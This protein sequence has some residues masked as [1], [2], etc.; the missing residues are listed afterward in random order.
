MSRAPKSVARD[1]AREIWNERIKNCQIPSNVAVIKALAERGH[2]CTKRTLMRWRAAPDSG[3]LEALTDDEKA[4]RRAKK[5]VGDALHI[6]ADTTPE[7][8]EEAAKNPEQA[9]AGDRD[10]GKRFKALMEMSLPDLVRLQT[11]T[12]A[13]MATIANECMIYRASVLVNVPKDLGAFVQ[14]QA[15][16]TKEISGMDLG[17]STPTTEAKQETAPTNGHAPSGSVA[18]FRNELAKRRNGGNGHHPA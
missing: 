9:E 17:A 1:L 4:L 5:A 10:L 15:I 6:S 11:K 18:V 2:K 7:K 8:V 13:A 3:F 12:M 14:A 16:A